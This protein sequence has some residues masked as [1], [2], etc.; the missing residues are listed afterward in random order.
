MKRILK[1][2][3]VGMLAVTAAMAQSPYY[4]RYASDNCARP[5][6]QTYNNQPYS[7]QYEPQY[8][9]A[10]QQPQA[11]DRGSYREGNSYYQNDRYRENER[12]SQND[13]YRDGGYRLEGRRPFDHSAAIVGGGAAVGAII[14]G[15]AGN[16]KGAA[17]GALSGGAAGL[18]YNRL[19]R[20]HAGRY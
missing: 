17:I 9:P 7:Y 16:G 11:W 18:I 10:Y 20:Q 6:A 8:E 5:Q 13:R 12:F 4:G 2:A 1:F 15:L 3:G 19:I 14:G